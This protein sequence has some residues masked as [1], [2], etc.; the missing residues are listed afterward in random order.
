MSK[1]LADVSECERAVQANQ[2]EI[3]KL[4]EL[5]SDLPQFATD[6]SLAAETELR[7]ADAQQGL[8]DAQV[9][10]AEAGKEL[11]AARQARELREP[12]YRRA[13]AEQAE[14]ERLLDE[15]QSHVQGDLCPLCGSQ[16]QSAALLLTSIRRQRESRSPNVDVTAVYPGLIVDESKARDQL[17]SPWKKS[18]R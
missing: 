5:L 12:E 2:A 14:R 13:V 16:F 3:T 10:C 7:I 17:S 18:V 9:R 4:Q 6:T 8:R 11:Q 15:L 1:A